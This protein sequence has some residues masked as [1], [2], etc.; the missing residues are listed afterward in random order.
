MKLQFYM[1][2]NPSSYQIDTRSDEEFHKYFLE[3][4]PEVHP[5][6]GNRRTAPK[7]LPRVVVT[8]GS[9]GIRRTNSTQDPHPSDGA[10]NVA[11]QRNPS[12]KKRVVSA[13]LAQVENDPRYLSA[14]EHHEKMQQRFDAAAGTSPIDARNF[15]PSLDDLR[16]SVAICEDF[17]LNYLEAFANRIKRCGKPGAFAC[18]SYWCT[19]CRTRYGARLLEDTQAL[20]TNR[21]G[22]QHEAARKALLHV[23][24]LNDIVIPDPDLDRDY[25]V[26]FSADVVRRDHRDLLA[27]LRRWQR[28]RRSAMSQ[29]LE[30]RKLSLELIE[31]WITADD[32][33]RTF[34]SADNM[35][36]DATRLVEFNQLIAAARANF[37]TRRNRLRHPPSAF[38]SWRDESK[39]D[40][41]MWQLRRAHELDHKDV[42]QLALGLQCIYREFRGITKTNFPERLKFKSS[43]EKVMKR[44]RSKLYRLSKAFPDLSLIGQFELELVDLRHAI[45]GAHQHRV[46]SKTLRILASQERKPTKLR[47]SKK[48]ITPEAERR[49]LKKGIKLR[50]LDEARAR[51]AAND[52]IPEDD[53]PGLQYAVL[54]HMH[55]LVDLNGANRKEVEQWLTGKAAGGRRFRG[56]WTLNHQVMIKKL[57]ENKP[58]SDSLRDISFYPFK[59]PVTFNYENTAPKPDEDLSEEDPANFTDEALALLAWLQHGIGHERLRLAINWPSMNRDRRGRKPNR[60]ATSVV[61]EEEFCEQLREILDERGL[62]LPKEPIGETD[63]SELFGC[64][65]INETTSY[66]K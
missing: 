28:D 14:K 43:I 33:D 55:V 7:G 60:S 27:Y 45:G 51:I 53:F 58:V 66:S 20:L 1:S 50:L 39:T 12:R 11:R 56:Q 29:L 59:A 46:K 13:L 37:K 41:Y 38:V 15:A 61:D 34:F 32:R 18:G 4:F 49:R 23:T 5:I 3:M 44:E 54:L 25:M 31:D 36:A 63:L 65:P 30:K 64:T 47:K 48:P 16:E 19:A 26:D 40:E 9:P 17:H 52:Q 62:H 2:T 6:A 57:F 22:A 8:S 24:I 35:L 21:Y 42:F 10:T